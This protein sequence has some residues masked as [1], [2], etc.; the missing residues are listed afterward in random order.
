[1]CEGGE[2]NGNISVNSVHEALNVEDSNLVKVIGNKG[3]WPSGGGNSVDFGMSFFA[4]TRNIVG[5]EVIGNDV[6]NSGSSG[7]CFAGSLSSGVQ[8]SVMRDNFALNCNAKKAA[9]AGGSDNLAGILLSGSLVQANAI[10]TNSVRDVNGYLT[11]GIAE[12]NR[13]VGLPSSNEVVGNSVFGTFSGG[14]P[15]SLVAST[16][17]AVNSWQL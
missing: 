1:L 10:S 7:L 17:S 11:Y 16:K 5:V 12:L 13:G 9:V 3:R 8:H 6:S 2:F 15:S 4:N 14:S